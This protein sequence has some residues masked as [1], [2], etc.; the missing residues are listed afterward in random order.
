M[1]HNDFDS[2]SWRNDTESETSGPA[3]I[4]TDTED[5][6]PSS[7]DVNGN[8]R[9]S[10]A[11]EDQLLATP[12]DM[13][14]LTG[15]DGTL[16]CT[17]DTPL[18]ENDG[19]KDAFISY[20]VTTHTDF[21]SFQRYDFTVRRRFTDFL[22]LYK[23]LYR[24]Y[25]ACAVPPLPDKHK[26]EYVRG[27]RFGPDFTHRRAWSLHRFIKRLALHP[28][29]R[30]A[31]ILAIFLESPDWNAHMRLRPS[32]N[33][34]GSSE[35]AGR[36]FDNFTD[37]LVNA[38]TKV[39]KPDK[40]FIEVKEKADKLDEDL[41]HVE[42]VVSRVTRRESD[43]ETDYS[44]LAMQ[45]RKLVPLEPDLEVPLQI[46]AASIEETTRGIKSLKDHTDQN[47]LGSLRDM[48]AYIVSLKTLLKTREQKQLDYEA[49]VDY[50]TK[51]VGER[52]NLTN[53]PSSYYATNPLTSSPASF[54]RS[55]MED[56]RGLNHE[57]TRRD[58]VRKLE[59]R[60]DELN[61]EVETS[62]T[63][64]EMFDEEV[65]REIADF[66]RIKAV[67]FRDTLG[68]LSQKHVEFYQGVLAT[69]ERFIVEMEDGLDGGEVSSQQ[70]DKHKAPN[71]LR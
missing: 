5:T 42:K 12:G 61:R 8:R 39:H 3:N 63:T 69:W 31:P 27:D 15:L 54:I 58:R 18:K 38:F 37:T 35:G 65:V 70:K 7:H 57:T 21:K 9:M 40:R 46:F 51:A 6:E 56:M 55:K 48:E 50:R 41:S 19:T 43:L 44:E 29:L 47:Y 23:T 20:L 32:R 49:L 4:H 33:S 25:P 10:L 45:F 52:D 2:V 13:T 28:V 22:F 11:S 60:I 59:V 53:N 66:E 67:E 71:E 1:D 16:E 30:R 64:S 62:K 14:Y 26:M 36:I 68:A 17:V 24:E 34:T